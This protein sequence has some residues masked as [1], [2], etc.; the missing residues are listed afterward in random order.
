MSTLT[1]IEAAV[2]QLPAAERAQLVRWLQERF[3]P[4]EGL[5]LREDVAQEL[6]AARQEIARG[7]V[8]D[9]EQLKRPARPD[10]R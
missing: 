2:E 3:D 8:A 10:S 7:E 5:E 1:E 9:W 4:D 6:D